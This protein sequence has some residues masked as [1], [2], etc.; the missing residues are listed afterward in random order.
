MD[1]GGGTGVV[2]HS[3][4]R[5]NPNVRGI[6][7]DLPYVI[8]QKLKLEKHPGLTHV[9]GDFFKGLPSGADCIFMKYILHDWN[10]WNA[11]LILK[12]CANALE[13]G[14]SLLICEHILEEHGTEDCNVDAADLDVWMLTILDGKE[15]TI[16]EWNILIRSSGFHIERVQKL[17]DTF[18][19]SVIQCIRD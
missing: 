5:K 12:S 9:G 13:P 7:F 8:D 14:K 15:R 10:D 17:N 3:I 16:S 2:L 18:N 4:L 1:V 11:H 6:N 19:L